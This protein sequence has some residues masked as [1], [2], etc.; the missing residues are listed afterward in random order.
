MNV[1][2]VHEEPLF[3]MGKH[4]LGA[5]LV[6]FEDSDVNQKRCA[7]QGRPN[8]VRILCHVIVMG[9]F[10]LVQILLCAALVFDTRPQ[11]SNNGITDLVVGRLRAPD[12]ERDTATL[13]SF[14]TALAQHAAAT[15]TH[16]GAY[17]V[18]GVP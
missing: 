10:N 17:A 6:L 7:K 2:K 1:I 14:A 3:L 8:S 5:S 16:I 12:R 18:H 13:A 15:A 4:S 9:E 11:V